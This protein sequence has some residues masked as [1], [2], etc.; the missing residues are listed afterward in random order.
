MDK[1]EKDSEL[2]PVKYKDTVDIPKLGYVDDILDINKCGSNAV[3]MNNYT[4]EEIGKRKLQFSVDKCARMHVEGKR[5]KGGERKKCEDLYI[6]KWEVSKITVNEE[7]QLEDKYVG[8]VK[9]KEVNEYEYLGNIVESNGSHSKTIKKR[10]SK[11]YGVVRDIREILEG[12]YFG[13][14]FI[15]ALIMLRNSM[16]ISVLLYNLE[17]CDSISKKDIKLLEDVDLAL[18]RGSLNLSSKVNGALIRAELGLT[19]M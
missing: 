1:I 19:S 16:L 9:I 10:V 8:R 18:L 14:Y 2:T 7:I 5:H 11:G 13:P 6:D 4:R 3:K 17:V 15:E 12:T